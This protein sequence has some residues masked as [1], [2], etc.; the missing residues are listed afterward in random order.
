MRA[1]VVRRGGGLTLLI[2]SFS[3]Y[4]TAHDLSFTS[5]K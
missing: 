3:S 4:F 2:A 5:L 1:G